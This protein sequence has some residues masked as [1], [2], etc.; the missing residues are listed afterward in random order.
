M[1]TDA[2]GKPVRFIADT[3][4]LML[5]SYYSNEDFLDHMYRIVSGSLSFSASEQLA[6]VAGCL[7]WRLQHGGLLRQVPDSAKLLHRQ[8]AS[9]GNLLRPRLWLPVLHLHEDL[10]WLC[11]SSY[12]LGF[13]L[14]DLGNNTELCY[15]RI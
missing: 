1:L 4:L 15:D 5:D 3:I 10:G 8:T 11:N 13:S 6:A 7:L 9:G 2:L 12:R 14:G